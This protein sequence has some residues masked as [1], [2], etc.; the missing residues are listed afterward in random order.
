[1]KERVL[2]H[3]ESGALVVKTNKFDDELPTSFVFLDY[4]GFYIAEWV[5][6]DFEDL[7]EL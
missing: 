5:D 7:G 3:K 2:I 6:D 4:N 1:M